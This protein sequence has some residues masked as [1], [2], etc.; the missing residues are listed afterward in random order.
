MYDEVNKGV[1]NLKA[2][3][4]AHSTVDGKLIDN[5]KAHPPFHTSG[6]LEANNTGAYNK[7]HKYVGNLK[8]SQ[9]AANVN[10]I[11]ILLTLSFMLA[12]S[13]IG[14]SLLPTFIKTSG[15]SFLQDVCAFISLQHNYKCQKLANT[16]LRRQ[17]G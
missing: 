10:I 13:K 1:G 6:V 9:Q 11:V 17:K 7:V 2:K 4:Q 16:F 15:K 5:Q 12:S 8:A 14:S 3:Q